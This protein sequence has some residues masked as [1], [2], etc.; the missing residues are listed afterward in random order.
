M[1][2]ASIVILLDNHSF[3]ILALDPSNDSNLLTSL[4]LPSFFF[5]FNKTGKQRKLLQVHFPC[6]L[7]FH[8]KQFLKVLSIQSLA[9]VP[10]SP[11]IPTRHSSLCHWNC[12]CQGHQCP[13]HAES[14][15]PSSAHL[16]WPLRALD[17]LQ[18]ASLWRQIL[19]L[20]ARTFCSPGFPPRHWAHLTLSVE[21]LQALSLT[22]PFSDSIHFLDD[23]IFTDYLYSDDHHILS[24]VRLFSWTLATCFHHP[25]DISS[26]MSE[27]HLQ[28]S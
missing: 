8:L 20:I 23:L 25:L 19:P 10:H 5:F 11:W 17:R 4:F 28:L 13:P 26:W 15:G 2:L 9:C 14:N 18:Y 22:Y 3:S 24:P 7:L 6:W 12:S 1:D 21:L 16:S 27:R